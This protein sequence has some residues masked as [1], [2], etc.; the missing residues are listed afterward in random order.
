MAVVV[1]RRCQRRPVGQYR[2]R[3]GNHQAGEGTRVAAVVAALRQ[4]DVDPPETFLVAT[5]CGAASPPVAE[6]SDSGRASMSFRPPRPHAAGDT[7]LGVAAGR[8][9]SP[10][11][12]PVRSAP[13][14]SL[15]RPGPSP[16]TGQRGGPLTP[17]ADD[18]DSG[19]A[20]APFRPSA[21]KYARSARPST[22]ARPRSSGESCTPNG[23][24]GGVFWGEVVP[25][26]SSTLTM[27]EPLDG[28]PSGSCNQTSL[29]PRFLSDGA[30]A[31]RARPCP[32]LIVL[33]TPTTRRGLSTCALLDWS[34]SMP[35]MSVRPST[36]WLPC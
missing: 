30:S 23:L 8:R 29:R 19:R 36:P 22:V 13:R 21:P 35:T 4:R 12:S 26:P 16:P 9:R 28:D 33:M 7:T 6:G 24:R 20:Q 34:L 31:A 25:D 1:R 10:R 15:D 32:P 2:N 18:P 17:V 5:A 3:E 27:S 14:S 11:R